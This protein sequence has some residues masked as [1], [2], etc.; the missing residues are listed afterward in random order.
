M[1]GN[2]GVG[3]K[4]LVRYSTEGRIA[5]ELDQDIANYNREFARKRVSVDEDGSLYIRRIE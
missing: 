1:V 3:R 5:R 2:D 4:R